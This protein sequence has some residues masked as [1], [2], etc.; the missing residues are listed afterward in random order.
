MYEQLNR[1]DSVPSNEGITDE[2]IAHAKTL[3]LTVAQYRAHPFS[4]AENSELSY[5]FQ[6]E[7]G[8]KSIFYFG[9]SH[10]NDP[11]DPQFVALQDS[12]TQAKPDLVLVEGLGGIN[13]Q[14]EGVREI[15]KS[16]SRDELIK[17]YGEAGEALRLAE[18]AGCDF[19]SPE[20]SFK[21]EMA[22]LAELGYSHK[23]IF[24]F[25]LHRQIYQYQREHEQRSHDELVPYL[26]P[27]FEEFVE[28]SG[29]DRYEIETYRGELLSDVRLD[30]N[31]Y[32]RETNPMA[33]SESRT[34]I[35][36][37]SFAS[38]H[39]RDEYFIEQIGEKLKQQN[40]IFVVYGFGHAITEEPAIRS[41]LA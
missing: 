20:P 17:T 39:F 28:S 11:S 36:E 18:E 6:V 8:L 41:L 23:D 5:T 29:C 22:H 2:K 1:E 35:N 27:L 13:E 34:T 4:R 32:D 31:E 9:S 33:S 14:K 7:N 12:F 30:S 24:R 16:T 10:T 38:N 21:S 26:Q 37:I 3:L 15:V 19:E 25:Y 40:R